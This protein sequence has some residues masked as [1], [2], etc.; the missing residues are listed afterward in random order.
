MEEEEVGSRSGRREEIRESPRLKQRSDRKLRPVASR[1]FWTV[2]DER[3]R[4]LGK[5]CFYI[6]CFI[7]KYFYLHPHWCF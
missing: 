5:P 6:G 4:I 1:S 2:K 3:R 7:L